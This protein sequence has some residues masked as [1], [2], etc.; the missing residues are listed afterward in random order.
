[1]K[2]K[3]KH[4]SSFVCEC[5]LLLQIFVYLICSPFV[6]HQLEIFLIDIHKSQW[7]KQTCLELILFTHQYL[8]ALVFQ[9]GLRYKYFNNN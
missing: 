1:M 3:S 4:F 5:L 7:S 9:I 6:M 8:K 2:N